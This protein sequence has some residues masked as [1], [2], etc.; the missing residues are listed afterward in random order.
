M[1]SKINSL[2]IIL[3][4]CLSG[5]SGYSDGTIINN[6]Q[7]ELTDSSPMITV[8]S[9]SRESDEYF[10]M[11]AAGAGNTMIFVLNTGK[12]ETKE[13]T[14][15]IDH[16]VE[17]KFKETIT[18]FGT[19]TQPDEKQHKIYFSTRS[20]KDKD[21][22]IWNMAIRSKG[23]ASAT[24][25]ELKKSSLV[26]LVSSSDKTTSHLGQVVDLG[27]VVRNKGNSASATDGDVE[28]TVNNNTEVYVLRC[29]VS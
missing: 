8:S 23:G 4:L 20:G 17:G 6:T 27:V 21:H 2:S 22:E 18:E 29:K 25:T 5:C 26:E 9:L 19:S 24:Y 12:Q 16:Y 14:F 1:K 13:I 7:E 3:L 11:E 10:A 15:W 28:D